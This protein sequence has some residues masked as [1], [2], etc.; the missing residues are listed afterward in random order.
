MS[1]SQFFCLVS[2][3][4]VAPHISHGLALVISAVSLFVAVCVF[5]VERK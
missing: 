2:G 5:F 1:Q 4:Y 3:L